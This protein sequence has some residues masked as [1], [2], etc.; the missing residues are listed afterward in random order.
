VRFEELIADA[1]VDKDEEDDLEEVLTFWRT[2]PMRAGRME[3]P[4]GMEEIQD[5]YLATARAFADAQAALTAW[6]QIEPDT[7]AEEAGAT[8]FGEAYH[9][10]TDLALE[11]DELLAAEGA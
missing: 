9:E 4:D 8:A 2:A 7:A 10:A 5:A 3:A 1:D 11:L 6:M